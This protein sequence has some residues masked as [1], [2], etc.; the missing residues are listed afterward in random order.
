VVAEGV[1]DED[2]LELICSLGCDLVQGYHFSKPLPVDEFLAYA[3]RPGGT[4]DAGEI[5]P[6]IDGDDLPSAPNLESSF[7]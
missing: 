7:E 3:L 6:P 2:T 5:S 1:E 4:D